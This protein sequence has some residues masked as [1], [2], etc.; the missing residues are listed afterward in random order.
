MSPPFPAPDEV[1]SRALKGAVATLSPTRLRVLARQLASGMT[2]GHHRSTRKGAG[3]EFAGHRAYLPG[4]DLRHLDR[5]ALLRHGRYLVREFFTETERSLFLLVDASA[6]MRWDGAALR[7]HAESQGT[8]TLPSTAPF[9]AGLSLPLPGTKLAFASLLSACLALLTRQ[10]GDPLGALFLSPEGSREADLPPLRPRQGEEQLERLLGHL[11]HCASLPPLL[12]VPESLPA[13]NAEDLAA[14]ARHRKEGQRRSTALANARL[15]RGATVV[16]FSDFLSDLEELIQ[17]LH[18]LSTRGR[19][20]LCVQL[21]DEAELEL[22]FSG[23]VHLGAGAG[24]PRVETFAPGAQ[25]A[26]AAALAAH[27]AELQRELT[28]L[29]ARSLFSSTS[30]HPT[31]LLRRII[32]ALSGGPA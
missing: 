2:L 3:V 32:H 28:R 26:Y 23:P 13:K 27:N 9:A 12:E 1:Q 30:A 21:L 24:G 29:H 10:S 11:S 8:G 20:M 7:R 15:E 6:S 17:L 4:D 14:Q 31:T 5:H 25:S 16:V 22:P 19:R 18:P